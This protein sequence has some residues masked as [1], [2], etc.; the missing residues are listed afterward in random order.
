[1]NDAIK[2]RIHAFRNAL[3]LAADTRSHECFAMGRWRSELN[4]FPHGCCEL[5]SNF[6]AQ[7]LHDSD[8][9]LQPLIVHMQTTDDF[10]QEFS[11]TIH[12]HVI[13]KLNGWYIDLTLNQ[14]EE[15]NRRIVIEDKTGDVG[16]LLRR[17]KH[18][19]G[20]VT[21]RGIQLNSGTE[22]GS[23]LYAWLRTTADSLLAPSL[24]NR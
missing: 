11:S 20:D 13:V 15:H 21:C 23:A 2:R 9:S 6:L 3:V 18:Y 14:F 5:A 19:S 22:D 12:S 1:M 8:P 17:I 7:Y 4:A 10:R 16:T 24:P